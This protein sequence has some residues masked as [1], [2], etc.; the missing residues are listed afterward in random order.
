[1][2]LLQGIHAGLRIALAGAFALLPGTIVWLSVLGAA[3]FLR[4]Q[5]R[6]QVL[7]AFRARLHQA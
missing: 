1:M 4:K 7:R 6:S 5:S 3:T 2:E